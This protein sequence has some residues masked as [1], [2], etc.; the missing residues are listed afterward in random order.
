MGDRQITAGCQR[1][2]QPRHTARRIG[3]VGDEMQHPQQQYGDR[4]LEVEHL[5]HHW[6]GQDRIRI[7]HIGLNHDGIGIAVQNRPAVRDR[8][9]IDIDVDHPRPRI[10]GLCHLVHITDRR[11]SRAQIQELGDTGIH[12]I[13]HT[14]AQ[15]ISV[16]AHGLGDIRSEGL[17]LTRKRAIDLEVVHPAHEI[18]VDPGCAGSIQVDTLGRPTGSAHR[19]LSPKYNPAGTRSLA[20]VFDTLAKLLRFT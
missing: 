9:R 20:I 18:V 6:V 4:L 7:G 12:Q 3:L 2:L 5:A 8:D 16:G 19:N 15:Q 17:D 13:T 10:A 11:N 1:L 14:A